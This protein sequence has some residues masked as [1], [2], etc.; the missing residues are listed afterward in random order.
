MESN[1]QRYLDGIRDCRDV[2]RLKDYGIHGN[3]YFFLFGDVTELMPRIVRDL[4][5]SPSDDGFMLKYDKVPLTR[6]H[7]PDPDAEYF[8]SGAVQVDV[9]GRTLE[10]YADEL[11]EGFKG[12]HC[13][14]VSLVSKPHEAEYNNSIKIS[15]DE[16][17]RFQ[18]ER[19]ILKGQLA[20]DIGD[21]LMRKGIWTRTNSVGYPE[22][23]WKDMPIVHIP[24]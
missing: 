5:S 4:E 14:H 10:D 1:L 23:S 11:I 15:E 6:I 18:D 13:M 7:K 16:L 12:P 24:K 2:G 3:R 17:S 21:Y 9:L 22:S 20:V 19:L 8:E